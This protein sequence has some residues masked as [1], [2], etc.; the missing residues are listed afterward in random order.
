MPQQIRGTLEYLFAITVFLVFLIY[1]T[2]LLLRVPKYAN[3]ET[4]GRQSLT[5]KILREYALQDEVLENS[6]Y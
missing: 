2:L 5:F 6:L 1:L 3:A 4:Y